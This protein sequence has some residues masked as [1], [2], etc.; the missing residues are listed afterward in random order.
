MSL[1][2]ASSHSYRC[3][4]PGLV[5]KRL[6][7]VRGERSSALS[8]MW[9]YLAAV[10]CLDGLYGLFF[11][12]NFADELDYGIVN[13]IRRCHRAVLAHS[14]SPLPLCPEATQRHAS[15]TS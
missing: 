1:T 15:T 12:A 14:S 5:A 2:C 7:T 8:P 4:V 6:V 10:F 9:Y 11:F 3:V 13:T